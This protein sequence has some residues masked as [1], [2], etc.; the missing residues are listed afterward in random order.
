MNTVNLELSDT[1]YAI[2]VQQAESAGISL[3]KWIALFLEQ[4]CILAQPLPE[5]P[6]A[7][8]QTEAEKAAR[9]RFRRHAG[10]IDLGYA[11]GAD[12]DSIDADLARAYS[13]EEL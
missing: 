4:Q 2:L 13:R 12:N 10:A 1:V 6:I 7:V 9:E 5:Q 3:S 11:V 8:Q